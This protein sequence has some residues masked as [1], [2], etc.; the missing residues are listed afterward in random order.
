MSDKAA[1]GLTAALAANATL[2]AFFG[3]VVAAGG[4][5]VAIRLSIAELAP[6]WGGALRLGVASLT[7]WLIVAARR[8]PLPRGRALASVLLYGAVSFGLGLGCAYWSLARV[9]AGM[10]S[11]FLSLVPLSTVLLAPLHGLEALTW[12]KAAGALLAVAGIAVIANGGLGAGIAPAALIGLVGIPVALAEGSLIIKAARPGD[13]MA[14]NAVSLSVG[15]AILAAMSLL[16]GEPRALPHTGAA[17]AALGYLVV[18]G[19]V[20]LFQLSLFILSRWPASKVSYAF[21]LMPLVSVSASV[22]LTGETVTPT[23]LLGA[24]IALAGVWLGA[25]SAAPRAAPTPREVEGNACVLTC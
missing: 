15:A 5:P 11:V 18:I 4:N 21:V 13:P 8:A 16:L 9:P 22:L 1:P 7:F 12:R 25:I 19:S 24:A 10:A 20:L 17:W 3:Y 23:L 14:T 2:V 6:F